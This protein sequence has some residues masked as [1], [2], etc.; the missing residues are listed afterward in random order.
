MPAHAASSA[1]HNAAQ[2]RNVEVMLDLEHRR[3]SAEITEKIS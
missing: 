3:D 1:A 2:H